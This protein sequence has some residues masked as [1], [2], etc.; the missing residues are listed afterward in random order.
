MVRN[1]APNTIDFNAMS[2]CCNLLANTSSAPG[3]LPDVS[4]PPYDNVRTAE[5]SSQARSIT[6]VLQTHATSD[7]AADLSQ[8]R[9]AIQECHAAI[10]GSDGS[11]AI[12]FEQ[13]VTLSG[14]VSTGD[15]V[16]VVSGHNLLAI[17]TT[18]WR[19]LS[20]G[21]QST[22]AGSSGA[23]SPGGI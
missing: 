15:W 2:G 3:L 11:S 21:A 1:E 19:D 23:I 7:P 13:V 4:T 18:A 22:G 5:V 14:R 16:G 20:S 12:A 17:L 10:S 6:E 8:L 9:S